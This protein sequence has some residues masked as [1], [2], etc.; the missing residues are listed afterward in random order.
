MKKISVTGLLCVFC[1]FTQ[2]QIT[3]QEM[4]ALIP[5]ERVNTG[6]LYNRVIPF[7]TLQ[8]F[9]T[10][11]LQDGMYILHINTSQGQYQEK[12]FVKH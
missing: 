8:D 11:H 5:K 9:N 1:F 10:A 2:A 3:Q 7:I 12:L 4:D 6:I